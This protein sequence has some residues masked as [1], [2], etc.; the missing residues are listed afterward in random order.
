[1]VL[2]PLRERDARQ[3]ARAGT[4]RGHLVERCEE[5]HRGDLNRRYH[6][7][8]RVG[9]IINRSSSAGLTAELDVE[10][11]TVIRAS[12]A[13]GRLFVEFVLPG[14]LPGDLTV[15][16]FVPRGLVQ[17]RREVPR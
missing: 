11:L 7:R 12:R 17:R 15:G 16:R 6:D 2:E 4:T 8:I 3:R 9:A 13:L 5:R 10:P 1:M 14:D